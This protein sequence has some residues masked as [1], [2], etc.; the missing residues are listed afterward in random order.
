MSVNYIEIQLITLVC[1]NSF[2]KLQVIIHTNN[3]DPRFPNHFL[4]TPWYDTYQNMYKP[5]ARK[6]ILRD[7]QLTTTI[8][9]D[10]DTLHSTPLYYL[11]KGR[12]VRGEEH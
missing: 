12:V 8:F 5:R 6:K 9:S 10:C 4:L 2:H 3:S 1:I 11:H 7:F